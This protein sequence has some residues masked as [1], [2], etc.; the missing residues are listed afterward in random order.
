M[1]SLGKYTDR[2]QLYLL[3]ELLRISSI[4]IYF[5]VKG[6]DDSYFLAFDSE[7][8]DEIVQ[9]EFNRELLDLAL[10]LKRSG[11]GEVLF[12]Q[13][14]FDDLVRRNLDAQ[15][16]IHLNTIQAGSCKLAAVILPGEE[17]AAPKTA[18]AHS[19][20]TAAS[21]APATVTSTAPAPKA[22]T[23]FNGGWAYESVLKLDTAATAATDVHR[24]KVNM[25]T[26][27]DKLIA[28]TA[29]LTVAPSRTVDAL[30]PAT[31]A[32]YVC[33]GLGY[34]EAEAGSLVSSSEA[35]DEAVSV[36]LLNSDP[37]NPAS[38]P[39]KKVKVLKS[40]ICTQ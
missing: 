29:A 33:R 5:R 25:P 31:V 12:T 23:P 10:E 32:G 20:A 28:F 38:A 3:R 9:Y 6:V 7:V 18:A 34:S 15:A 26:Y 14:T 16:C 1:Q 36:S 11:T 27:G 8:A 17:I 2:D 13:P 22:L 21:G 35:K 19:P 4:P 39:M 30:A 24:I 37:R 40:I